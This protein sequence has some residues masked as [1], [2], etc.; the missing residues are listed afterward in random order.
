MGCKL[1]YFNLVK[2]GDK[3]DNVEHHLEFPQA[4]HQAGQSEGGK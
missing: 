4:D 1:L 2:A 3:L